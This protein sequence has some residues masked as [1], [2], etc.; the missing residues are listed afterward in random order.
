MPPDSSSFT[1]LNCP[2]DSALPEHM[3]SFSLAAP[4]NTDLWRKPPSR[5]TSTAPILYTALRN[6]FIAAEVTVA[7]EWELEWDQGGLVI[8]AGAPPGRVATATSREGSSNSPSSSPSPASS[9]SAPAPTHPATPAPT[10]QNAGQHPGPGA[11]AA[12]VPQSQAPPA[13]MPPAPASKWVKVGL[14]FCNGACHATSVVATSDGADWA[15]AD[16]VRRPQLRVKIERIGCALWVWYEDGLAGWKKL[17]EVTW[18]F[19]GVED[20]A[21]RVGVY[22]SRPANF[23]MS[24]YERR[25]GFS[26][27]PRNLLPEGVSPNGPIEPQPQ[28]PAL[29]V[30]SSTLGIVKPCKTTRTTASSAPPISAPSTTLSSIT[31]PT[32]LI[33]STTTLAPS[34]TSADVNPLHTD[35]RGHQLVECFSNGGACVTMLVNLT[36]P[37]DKLN[38]NPPSSWALSR[39]V[40]EWCDPSTRERREKELMP[41]CRACSDFD[42]LRSRDIWDT[43]KV[44]VTG[45][46]T[47]PSPSVYTLSVSLLSFVKDLVIKPTNFTHPGLNPRVQSFVD[48]WEDRYG[49][50]Q[51]SVM[52]GMSTTR[53]EGAVL[54]KG[55]LQ[56]PR[57]WPY[58][59]PAVA[60]RP[61]VTETAT[62]TGAVQGG[63]GEFV[64]LG[65]VE[66]YPR[67]LDS[68]F[69]VLRN[70]SQSVLGVGVD[71]SASG[72]LSSSAGGS[73]EGEARSTASA[74]QTLSTR[75]DVVKTDSG[76][77]SF[78]SVSE[79]L[80]PTPALPSPSKPVS[81]R[82]VDGANSSSSVPA[83]SSAS[84]LP[85]PLPPKSTST[86]AAHMVKTM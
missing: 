19:W 15:R 78:G 1:A 39:L 79:I 73:R 13:Y 65:S 20:K 66:W 81:S 43:F 8:F 41:T 30:C 36:S 18:F 25:Q 64:V 67:P 55:L 63:K 84:S 11:A 23:G 49:T 51:S 37:W 10:S 61:G 14:E 31:I 38:G 74:A 52:T 7:A 53:V 22:A 56:L 35:A 45:F 44:A 26:N 42:G 2:P 85:A 70:F 3:G 86:S 54:T 46:C 16:I 12:A 80:S 60:R 5:D 76:V 24:M 69:H 9:N 50:T 21:V 68:G 34:T 33:R 77:R 47:T 48:A 83:V 72:A 62:V 75:S 27:S 58:T 17:R 57:N 71:S 6:P 4:P 40:E 59:K 82:T 29:E 32:I 28:A